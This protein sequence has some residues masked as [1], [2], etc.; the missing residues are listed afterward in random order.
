MFLGWFA[1]KNSLTEAVGVDLFYRN[2][3]YNTGKIKNNV[4]PVVNG[5]YNTRLHA[6]GIGVRVNF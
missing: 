6:G 5:T 4:N 2:Q 3:L 1:C